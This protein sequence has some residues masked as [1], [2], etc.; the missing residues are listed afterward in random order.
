VPAVV[1]GAARDQWGSAEGFAVDAPFFSISSM[2]FWRLAISG[3]FDVTP[4]STSLGAGPGEHPE[5]VRDRI[6][7][8]AIGLARIRCRRGARTQGDRSLMWE[9]PGIYGGDGAD[10]VTSTTREHVLLVGAIESRDPARARQLQ[11]EQI[12]RAGERMI[13]AM[14]VHSLEGD[15]A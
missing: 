10:L 14:R 5:D 2:C 4:P 15:K 3:T 7:D 8:R 12:T 13:A 9:P 6:K 11:S 1:A